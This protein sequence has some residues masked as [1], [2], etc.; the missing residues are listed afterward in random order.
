M[1]QPAYI[2]PLSRGARWGVLASVI[3]FHAGVGWALASVQ[4]RPLAVGDVASMEVRMVTEQAPRP[5]EPEVQLDVPPPE[6]TPPPEVPQLESMIQPPM[7]DLPPPEFPVQAPPPKPPKPRPAPP[8]PQPPRP[9]PQQA[10]PA[11]APAPQ[12]TQQA[13]TAAPQTL[14][15]FQV[16]YSVRPVLVYPARERRA[17]HHGTTQIRAYIDASGVPQQITVEKSSGYPALDEAAVE[18]MRKAR[19]NT[20][21]RAFSVTGPFTFNL[22]E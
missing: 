15:I 3:V 21:G 2:Q 14:S 16:S 11:P 9:H 10:T 19:V 18:A 20:G 4:P 13:A 1:S 22:A 7:P 8:K 17:G 12:P 6:D 5:P